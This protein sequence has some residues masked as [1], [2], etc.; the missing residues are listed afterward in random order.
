MRSDLRRTP[1]VNE[2]RPS[3]I[4]KDPVNAKYFQFGQV[5]VWIMDRLDGTRSFMTVAEELKA[6][7][8]ARTTAAAIQSFYYKLRQL[9]L[10][11]RTT[12]EK[13]LM[14]MERL[15]RDRKER[16]KS[17]Q[18]TLFRMRFSFGDPDQLFTRMVPPLKFF[19]T[20]RFVIVS[21]L[22]FIAYIWV[23]AEN[24]ALFTLGLRSLYNPATYTP[25]FIV[26]LYLSSVAII[27]VHEFGHGLTCKF[28][29]G[30]VHEMGAMLLYFSPALYCNVSDAYTFEKRSH[31]LWVT[32]AGGWIQLLIAAFAAIVWALTEPG[33]A[34]H[35]I[36][37]ITTLLGGGLSVLINYNPLLP[38]DGYYALVEMVG[39][40][41]LR[42][43]SM[44]LLR[45]ETKRRLLRS[46]IA[47][48]AVTPREFRIMIVYGILA[49]S[50]TV[51][52]LWIIGHWAGSLAVRKFGGWGW[53]LVAFV[54]W[55]LTRKPRQQLTRHFK[56]W[57]AEYLPPGPRRQMAGRSAAAL[58]AMLLLSLVIPW[59]VRVRGT[60]IVEP[61]ARVWVR[62]PEVAWVAEVFVREGDAV[63][64]GQEIMRLRNPD[65][66][67]ASGRAR[68]SV[69]ALEREMARLRAQADPGAERLAQLQL[70]AARHEFNALV[71]REA[72]LRLRAPFSGIVA[73]PY[74]NELL[75][76]RTE[77][78]DSLVEI[79]GDGPLRVRIALAQRDAGEVAV[80]DLVRIRF[81]G[82]AR[83]KWTTRVA[84]VG[85][86]A[87]AEQ[88]ELVA[89]LDAPEPAPFLR[90]G[91]LGKAK[92][93][94]Q[95]TS[96]AGA[97]ARSLRRLIR[98]ERFL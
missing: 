20:R 57:V 24:W 61:A 12:A 63:N 19:W 80:G 33:S 32:F 31:R 86:A 46:K 21:V 10:T 39:I 16:L 83:S 29:G 95:R 50:Y 5:E 3:Y 11:E 75:G 48:A 30:E 73:T 7:I 58:A 47:V 28:F 60:A 23:I 94:V 59:T 54:V 68:A 67:L 27:M 4:I 13:S 84:Q 65:L 69:I 26:T 34:V 1:Q 38:L 66:E 53:V 76:A 98:T 49:F 82:E 77:P 92:V 14:L 15:R 91:T 51:L 9:G 43:R 6:E 25:M 52:V 72:S 8:G 41:N 22:F 81:P 71:D 97:T 64:A 40:T 18:S 2:G 35:R 93:S 90:P 79:L 42:E 17:T 96:V 56:N 74:L 62:P 70:Q 88:V 44:E 45:N 36:A 85:T 89:A 78:G 55:R 87:R 37:F